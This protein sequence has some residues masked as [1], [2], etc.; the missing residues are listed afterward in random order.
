MF[1]LRNQKVVKKF[2]GA[3][4]SVRQVEVVNDTM[5][6]GVGIDR[7]LRIWDLGGALKQKVTIKGSIDL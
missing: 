5:L 7:F 6:A 4:G 1:D 3:V 2:K